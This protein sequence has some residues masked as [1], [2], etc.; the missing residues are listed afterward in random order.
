M[1]LEFALATKRNIGGNSK[2]N[3]LPKLFKYMIVVPNNFSLEAADYATAAALKTALQ[4]AIKAAAA[5]RIYLFPAIVKCEDLTQETTYDDSPLDTQDVYDGQ[6]RFKL[7]HS[8]NM[9]TVKDLATHYYKNEYRAIMVDLEGKGF[10]TELSDG[11]LSGASIALLKPEKIDISDGS[12]NTTSPMYLCLADPKDWNERGRL[13]DFSSVIREIE[14]LVDVKISLVD[15][16]A[17]AAAG[18]EVDVK[19]ESDG[20]PVSGLLLADFILYATD[21]VTEQVITSTAEDANISGRYNIV[22][23]GGNLFE[24]GVLALRAASALTVS[25]FECP[26]RLRLTVDIP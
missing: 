8:K 12:N 4:T 16:D 14:P 17:F 21:G 5:D 19:V 18:F 2:L 22:A 6:Y 1:S 7:H 3:K 20:T 25:P 15:G 23:P 10:L 24:D 9:F 26:E 13:L 11:S